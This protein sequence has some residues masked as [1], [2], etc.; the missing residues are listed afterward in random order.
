MFVATSG[1]LGGKVEFFPVGFGKESSNLRPGFLGFFVHDKATFRHFA[2]ESSLLFCDFTLGGCAQRCCFGRRDSAT[3][4]SF[5]DGF[6]FDCLGITLGDCQNV[7]GVNCRGVGHVHR[8]LCRFGQDC[9][10]ACLNRSEDGVR[11][12]TSFGEHSLGFNIGCRQKNCGLFFRG[13]KDHFKFRSESCIC[14]CARFS[15]LK[16]LLRSGDTGK[17][18]REFVAFSVGSDNFASKGCDGF[19]DIIARV[20]AHHNGKLSVRGHWSSLSGNASV[21][22]TARA[23]TNGSPNRRR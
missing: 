14:R 1:D 18:C 23:A 22:P 5:A 8:T 12:E 13:P 3:S 7:V 15:V 6:L 19:V 20:S 16:R 10:G 21:Y 17:F 11:F 4:S 2:V 9:V